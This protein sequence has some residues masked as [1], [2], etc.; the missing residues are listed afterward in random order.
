MP[1]MR[2][3]TAVLL[4]ASFTALLWAGAVLLTA[5]YYVPNAG[6]TYTTTLAWSQ[7]SGLVPLVGWRELKSTLT[8]YDVA[9][10]ASL[11]TVVAV[12]LRAGAST[13]RRTIV[14]TASPVILLFPV[15]AVGCLAAA[16]NAVHPPTHDGEFLAEGWPQNYVFAFWTLA[17]AAL[18]WGTART[19]TS[20]GSGSPK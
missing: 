4:L 18:A 15:N 11:A 3:R 9:F 6:I 8:V 20:T 12:V 16:V 7:L 5:A 13:G 17:T 14:L 1:I 19:K 2:I 10:W